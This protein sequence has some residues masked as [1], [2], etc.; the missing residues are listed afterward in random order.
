MAVKYQDYSI[1]ILQDID[2]NKK[3]AL[4]KIGLFVRDEARLRTPVIS[5]NLKNSM[6]YDVLDSQV[7][8]GSNMKYAKKVNDRKQ[9]LT[10]AVKNNLDQI[11][12]II[13]SEMK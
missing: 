8:I 1:K 6:D 7:N 2:K 9:N 4:T 11:K 10:N 13:T 3:R 12:Y 5:G